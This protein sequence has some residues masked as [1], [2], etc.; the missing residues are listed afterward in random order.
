MKMLLWSVRK[1]TAMK[2]SSRIL[3]HLASCN[4]VE[5]CSWMML[6]KKVR[7]RTRSPGRFINFH[8]IH[9]LVHHQ[10]TSP[11]FKKKQKKWTSHFI[12]LQHVLFLFPLHIQWFR[13]SPPLSS[14]CLSSVFVVPP[15][16]S[17]KG[18]DRR[19]WCFLFSNCQGRFRCYFATGIRRRLR[20]NGEPSRIY[21]WLVVGV[22]S[23]PSKMIDRL[24]YDGFKLQTLWGKENWRILY[25]NRK[26]FLLGV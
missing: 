16:S 18:S 12:H 8:R 7:L 10:S 14:P 1:P 2:G 15:L 3:L 11:G 23:S 26:P 5:S 9:T 20:D 21:W 25:C 13:S 19:L 4:F 22:F 6:L 24:Q 17:F